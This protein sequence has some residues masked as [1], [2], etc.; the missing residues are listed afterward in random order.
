VRCAARGPFTGGP[1]N[2]RGAQE[3]RI[4]ERTVR[5]ILHWLEEPSVLIDTGVVTERRL[6]HGAD[7][8]VDV[9]GAG[10][11]VLLVQTALTAD[12]L[13]PI[14]QQP[15]L[16]DRYQTILY[17][18]RGYA[19]SSS[20]SAPGSIVR[21]AKDAAALLD[22]LGIEHAHVVGLSFSGAIA[23]QLASAVPDRVHSLTLIEPPPV[24]VPS[25]AEFR[26]A[27]ARLQESRRRAGVAAALDEFMTLLIGQHWRSETERNLPGSVT[28]LERD[29]ATFFDI[30]IPA[31]LGWN[32]TAAD[33]AL[34]AAP[35]LYVGGT[36]S[37]R[38]FAEVRELLLSWLP[39]AEDVL[40]VGA[41]HSLAIT[42]ADAIAS[43]LAA[44]LERHPI[45]GQRSSAR[46]AASYGD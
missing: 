7:L 25:A 12:E 5:L 3:E 1:K 16:A 29:A 46:S 21:D 14:A 24:H 28:Q 23:L 38:W 19:G 35:V 42:H 34:I 18:R 26:A 30:D 20:A 39:Q 45:P 27:N 43:N 41:D 44:F 36:D 10:E 37:G 13:L 31:L 32:Y 2:A 6:V 15:V 17:H 8:E 9:H 11:P 40:L 33:A 4:A 22:V